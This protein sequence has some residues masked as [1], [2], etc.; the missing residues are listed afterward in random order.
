MRVLYLACVALGF[1]GCAVAA[2]PQPDITEY[3][4]TSF[5]P[6]QG[7]PA[8]VGVIA[9]TTDG[10]LWLGTA[11]GVYRFDGVRFQRIETVG[12][13]PLLGEFITALEAPRSGGLW[14]GYQYGGASFLNGGQLRNFR[15][16]SGG[17]P[18]GSVGSFAVDHDG[19]VWAG[20]SRGI[21]RLSGD[22]WIDVTPTLGLPSPNASYIKADDSG[23]LWIESADMLTV[24][25][26][27]SSRVHVYDLPSYRSFERD[28]AGRIWNL[29]GGCL[30]LLDPSRDDVPPCRRMPKEYR[31]IWIIDR[32][33]NVWLEGDEGRLVI[34]PTPAVPTDL[35]AQAQEAAAPPL[36][37]TRSFNDGIEPL[38]AFLDREGNAWFGTTAGL[39]QLRVPRLRRYGPFEET[40]VLGAGNHNT[41]WVGTSHYRASPG[42]DF[43]QLKEGSMV[44][45]RGGPTMLT[46]SYRDA[47]GVLWMGGYGR[48]WKLTDSTWEEIPAPPPS[49]VGTDLGVLRRTQAIGRDT[50]GDLWLSVVR[51]GL[52]RLRNDQWERVTVPGIPATEY[53][54]A[55]YPD[56]DGSVWLGYA[57]GRLAS[58]TRDGWHLYTEKDGIHL[59]AVQVL[60]R[61]DD[62]LWIGGERGVQRLRDGHFDPL[63]GLDIRSSVTGLLQARNGD[64]WLDTATGA[65]HVARQELRRLEGDAS[66]T[67]AAERFDEF[68]GM[69]GVP[70]GGRPEPTVM[71]G[72]DGRIWFE[73]ADRFASLDA[74]EHPDASPAPDVIM[75]DITD[76]G[77]QR[78]PAASLALSSNVRNVAIDYT[79]TSLAIPSHVRFKYWLENFDRSWQE[80]GTRRTAYY[81]NLPPGHYVFHVTAANGSGT[82]NARGAS[83]ALT[84][85]PLFYQTLSFRILVTAVAVLLL[86]ALLFGRVRQIT[87]TQRRRLEQRLD[88]RLNERTR[89]ARELHDSLL[90]GFHA[91]MFRLEAV[92]QLLPDR[93]R[94]A[95][96]ALD[97]A[98]RLGDEAIVEGREAVENLRS[99][100]L[101][102]T[103]LSAALGRLGAE[104]GGA[105]PSQSR[106]EFR[107][108]VE[109]QTRELTANVRDD[110]YRIVREAVRNAY[111]HARARNIETDVTF[112]E[113]NFSIRV[114]DDGIGVDSQILTQGQRAGHWGLPGMRERSESLGG[115]LQVWSDGN[116]GT[117]VELR[118][119]AE[120]A[121]LRVR[122]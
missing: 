37:R 42:D 61:I 2:S 75:G 9:Q 117:E 81:N 73:A 122:R 28:A 105:I 51:Q 52:F 16:Q 19:V 3:L 86:A 55:I 49:L 21:A 50:R 53:P 5:G 56:R 102:E 31:D 111:Q 101:G 10:F 27:G 78:E 91:L 35:P 38:S 32:A 119:P 85:P 8:I 57:L 120:V 6:A 80:V 69:P 40:I 98:M 121:Y 23:N 76:D 48:L 68:D 62:Q 13:V 66:A 84:V 54:M 82:W 100:W 72:D 22:R 104:L 33:G 1:I 93:P 103:D 88:D 29:V 11:T 99:T 64:L 108:V 83:I 41:L 109:G 115:R 90:Q 59:A 87:E 39:E 17:L 43:F 113:M 110:A 47:T 74:N 18:F 114:R 30:Y 107:V 79:A 12:G 34:L 95:R 116:A 7:A 94:D 26:R 96:D 25:R 71:Q 92:R 112:G 4:R 20:T 46:A 45:Y 77:R 44:P 118:I 63:P 60:E 70:I 15:P 97:G 14:I 106:P 67:P 36:S 58:L 89:I 65:L 24:L